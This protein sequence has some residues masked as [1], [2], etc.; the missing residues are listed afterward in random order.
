MQQLYTCLYIPDFPVAALLRQE[1]NRSIPPVA[2]YTGMAPNC[3]VYAA[4]RVARTSGVKEGMPLA[5]GQSALCGFE[6]S[7][8]STGGKATRRQQEQ[9]YSPLPAAPGESHGRQDRH[10]C[11]FAS[12]PRP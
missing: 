3:F 11:L 4:N 12:E 6:N 1:R 9:G 10:S 5:E 7:S 8:C 2:V